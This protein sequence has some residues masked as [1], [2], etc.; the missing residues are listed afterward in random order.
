[1]RV[2]SAYLAPL[3][4]V[5]PVVLEQNEW[6]RRRQCLWLDDVNLRVPLA[7][8]SG[9]GSLR[10]DLPIYNPAHDLPWDVATRR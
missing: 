7:Y 5:E 8:E 6:V 2:R 4:N 1:M 9:V 10:N 3:G